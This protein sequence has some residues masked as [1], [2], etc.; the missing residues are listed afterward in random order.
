MPEV[1][2]KSARDFLISS[3]FSLAFISAS[4]I[5]RVPQAQFL[6]LQTLDL[7]ADLGRLLKLEFVRSL[8]HLLA[9]FLNLLA[10]GFGAQGV[11][12]ARALH[13]ALFAIAAPWLRRDIYFFCRGIK[14]FGGL[15]DELSDALGRDA[16]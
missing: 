12:S 4:Q 5:H 7:V 16:M 9:Q 13:L 15:C 10:N 14:L 1:V 11:Q 8:L 2:G 6:E 3:N